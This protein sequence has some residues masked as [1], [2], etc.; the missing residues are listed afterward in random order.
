MPKVDEKISKPATGWNT[1]Q[2]VDDVLA[3][4]KCTWAISKFFY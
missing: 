4:A 3:C 1:M 2:I